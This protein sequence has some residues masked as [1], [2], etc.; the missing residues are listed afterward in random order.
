MRA[1]RYGDSSRALVG[2][3]DA[4][5]LGLSALLAAA[6]FWLVHRALID[7]AYITMVE[8][9]NL[10]WHGDWGLLPGHLANTA[11]SPLN[12]ALL[13]LLILPLRD[14]VKAVGALYVLNG[15]VLAA[16]LLGLGRH[17]GLGRTLAVVAVPLLLLDPL[18]AS[19]VGM[20]T[21][22]A[23]TALVLLVWLSGAGR[24]AL[25]GVVAGL[26]VLARL[27]LAVVVVV[28]LLLRPRLWRRLHVV[29]ACAL[30]VAL[31]WFVFSWVALGSAVPDTLLIKTSSHW[32]HFWS[33]L[34]SRYYW[35]DGPAVTATLVACAVGVLAL[36]TWAW[37]R[38]TLARDPAAVLVL[39]CA[40]AAYY[41]AFLALD[42]SP[43]H[44]YYGI[45]VAA[46]VLCAC[47]AVAALARRQV[48]LLRVVAGA[49]LLVLIV[50]VGLAWRDATPTLQP[51]P[52]AMIESNWARPAQYARIG[53]DLR[54][55]VGAHA[56]VTPAGEIGNL[57]YHCHCEL[58]DRFSDRGQLAPLIERDRA[59]SALMRLNY[60]WL[61]TG[62][63]HPIEPQYHLVFRHGPD[64]SGWGWN[65]RSGSRHG[66]LALVPVVATGP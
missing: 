7:D 15:V 66:H 57:L 58:V 61:R 9:R 11:T 34:Y 18:L 20:E 5:V 51:M 26:T 54:A 55:R 37:W 45:P 50:P 22:L 63:L 30:L 29:A 49:A 13:A 19:T 1:N 52:V 6:V 31:P 64:R 59:H 24:P 38:P 41:L 65:I 36:A 39:G 17:L 21:M 33:G 32:G 43:F 62:T 44:W 42:V 4:V 8:A 48:P 27:D 35:Y 12:V 53:R 23:V 3:G 14:P 2:R 28:V 16:A 10:A 25:L 46:L 47:V 60:W 56:A 40:G